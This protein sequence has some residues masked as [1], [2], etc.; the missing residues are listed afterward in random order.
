MAEYPTMIERSTGRTS[1]ADLTLATYL[2]GLLDA[3]V[4]S[5]APLVS[6]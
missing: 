3:N 6:I 5:K 4:K 2:P 1:G